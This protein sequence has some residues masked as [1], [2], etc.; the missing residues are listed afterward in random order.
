MI[1]KMETSPENSTTDDEMRPEYDL[2]QLRGGVRGKYLSR[3][4]SR[5]H[6]VRLA[7]DIAEVFPTEEAVNAA[8]RRV[9]E[10]DRETNSPPVVAT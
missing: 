9:V 6:F 5:L 3:Y 2:T 4:R 1:L 8:L 10:L 7:P